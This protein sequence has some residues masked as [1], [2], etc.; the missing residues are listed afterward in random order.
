MSKTN[1]T[2]QY[3]QSFPTIMDGEVIRHRESKESRTEISASR[4]CM[5]VG[6][7]RISKKD[8]FE[9]LIEIINMAWQ[10]YQYLK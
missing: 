1:K 8:Q 4:N 6:D 5:M 9:D 7:I 10:E 2:F 3:C